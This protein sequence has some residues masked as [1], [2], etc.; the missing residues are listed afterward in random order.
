MVQAGE[1][2]TEMKPVVERL[3]GG[4]Q[5]EGGQFE[6]NPVRRK[7]AG[8]FVSVK[9]HCGS[10]RRRTPARVSSKARV[11][12]GARLISGTARRWGGR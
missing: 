9:Q 4:Q 3:A 1:R 8:L 11:G 6:L 12:R 7:P 10:P 5:A 2:Q